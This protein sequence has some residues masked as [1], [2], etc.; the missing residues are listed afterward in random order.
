VKKHFITEAA[1]MQKLAGINEAYVDSQGQL[2][3][4]VPDGW[5]EI[6][7]DSEPD[8]EEDIEIE[9]YS[10]PMEGWDEEHHDFISI[11]KTPEIDPITKKPLKSKYYVRTYLAFSDVEDSEQYDSLEQA[12]SKAV[13]IMNNI[14]SDWR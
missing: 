11:M 9:S 6:D 10:A 3:D 13:K 5:E 12:K 2:Q 8:E 7:V 1:R 4:L 14:K